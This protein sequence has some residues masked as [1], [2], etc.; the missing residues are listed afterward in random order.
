MTALS[1]EEAVRRAEAGDARAQYALAAHFARAGRREE[2]DKWLAAAAANGEPDAL[3][4]LATRMTHTKAGVIEAAPLLAEAAAKG[5]PSAAHFVAVLKALGLGFPRDEAAAAE[6]VGALAAAGHAPIRRSLEALRLLQ[7]ADDPRRDPVRLCASPDIVLY[8]GAVPPAVCTHV[9]AHAGPRLGPALVYDPRGA[10]MMRDP[11]RSS[12]TASL[13]PVDLDLAIV[14]VNR[15][16]SACAGLPDEQGE[17]LSVMRYRA[18]EQYRPHFDTVPPGP[19]F[20]RSG[21]RVKTALLY[22]NDGYEGGETEFSAPGLKIKGAPGDVVVFTNVR[23]DGTLD[24]ASRH[25]GLAVTSGEKWLASK[26][27][28]ERIFA[29]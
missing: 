7:Q 1:L 27:F 23:A 11:L 2:A 15:R 10:G 12:A 6:I 5:S 9:I 19:D 26:W 14:A 17:F 29:F 3:Y 20:D 18:G 21:Q 24:G 25:A 22:L 28:R 13:S 8:R 4:T 16:V